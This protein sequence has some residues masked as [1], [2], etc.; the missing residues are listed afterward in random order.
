MANPK[1]GEVEIDAPNG[2]RYTLRLT[3]NAVCAAQKRTGKNLRELFLAALVG[4]NIL[5]REFVWLLLQPS[6]AT[7]FDSLEKVGEF[8]DLWPMLGD[9]ELKLKIAELLGHRSVRSTEIYVRAAGR[10]LES[11]W[12]G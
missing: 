12:R 1:R 6:H 3:T 7:E 4:D 2:K 10:N 9:N 11:V 8:I 5:T